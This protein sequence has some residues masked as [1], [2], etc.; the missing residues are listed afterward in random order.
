MVALDT[1]SPH[2]VNYPMTD[3]GKKV[4]YRLRWVT[5]SG[6]KGG[7]GEVAEATVNG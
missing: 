6:E 5:T 1:S 7:W 4:W 2:V 3:A